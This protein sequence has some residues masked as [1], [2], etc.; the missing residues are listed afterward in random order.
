MSVAAHTEYR[1]HRC[2]H[3]HPVVAVAASSLS[4]A[5]NSIVQEGSKAI[6]RSEVN[7][8]KEQKG[9]KNHPQNCTTGY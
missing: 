1:T 3:H 4:A 2:V 7:A 9:G 8:A 5:S 6:D